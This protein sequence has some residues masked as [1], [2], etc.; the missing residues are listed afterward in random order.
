ME[1]YSVP[2]LIRNSKYFE[3]SE[4]LLYTKLFKTVFMYIVSENE[5]K[6]FE[7]SFVHHFKREHTYSYQH[8]KLIL[9]HAVVILHYTHNIQ[10]RVSSVLYIPIYSYIWKTV[11]YLYIPIFGRQS[12]IFLYFRVSKKS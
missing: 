5:W 11:L 7:N 8:I 1:I 2:N 12:Y 9:L 6:I 3:Q 4:F 10:C